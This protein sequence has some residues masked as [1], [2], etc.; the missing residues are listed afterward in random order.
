MVV[1][2]SGFK[3]RVVWYLSDRAAA[4]E[5]MHG[6][7]DYSAKVHVAQPLTPQQLSAFDYV[8]VRRGTF[9]KALE[10]LARTTRLPVAR[11][12]QVTH[13]LCH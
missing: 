11:V 8:W 12:H 10:G 6:E 2:G 3:Q 1:D 5:Q 4:V 13:R 9:D 7:K